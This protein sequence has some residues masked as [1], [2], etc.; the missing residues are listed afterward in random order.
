MSKQIEASD[1]RIARAVDLLTIEVEAKLNE[2][3]A[4]LQKLNRKLSKKDVFITSFKTQ[5]E[6][7]GDDNERVEMIFGIHLTP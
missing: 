4:Y 2:I 7:L 1:K 3:L 6:I 5:S